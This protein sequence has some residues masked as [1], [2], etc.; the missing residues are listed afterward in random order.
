MKR[1]RLLIPLLAFVFGCAQSRFVEP[2][3][4]GQLSVGG[5][6]GGPLIEYPPAV[7]PIPFLDAEV[8]YGLDSNLTVHGGLNLTSMAFGNFHMDAGVTYKFLNQRKY[9]PNLSVSPSFNLVY[10]VYDKVGKFWPVL[11]VNAYWNYGERR[12]YFYAGFNNY[13]EL[14]KTMANDQ[15]QAHHWLFS[16]QIGHILKGKKQYFQFTTEVKLLG[17][18]LDSKYSFIPYSGITGN[19]GATGIYLGF[20]WFINRK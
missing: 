12:N 20:R 6:F 9:I 8:G 18:N 19:M 10:D 15:P 5:N 11:D 13:F 4:K 16:P 1:I 2:L 3:D 7:I 17:I 14:S